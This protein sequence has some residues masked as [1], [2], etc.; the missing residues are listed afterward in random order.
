MYGRSQ[1]AYRWDVPHA[2]DRTH[3]M[4]RLSYSRYVSSRFHRISDSIYFLYI[5]YISVSSTSF[6]TRTECQPLLLS[7][8]K[9]N[10]GRLYS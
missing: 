6:T 4:D 2:A 5:L 7:Y 8:L 1:Q 9:S 10:A 3:R